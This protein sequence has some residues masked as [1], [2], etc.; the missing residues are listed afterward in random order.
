M[1]Q[2]RGFLT[3]LTMVL[4]IAALL[5]PMSASAG[6]WETAVGKM[7]VPRNA[8]ET[9]TLVVSGISVTIEPGDYPKGGPVVLQVKRSSD[10]QFVASFHPELNFVNPVVMD[11]GTVAQVIYESKSGPVVIPTSD[12]DGDGEVGEISSMHFSRYSGW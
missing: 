8:T 10:G 6:R 9:C 1:F 4:V 3:V 2:R 7:M 5:L 12:L 11:F